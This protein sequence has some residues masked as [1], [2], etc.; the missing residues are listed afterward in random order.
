[1]KYLSPEKNDKMG[2]FHNTLIE[3]VDWVDLSPPEVI[4]ILRMVATRVERLF[5]VS[6][7]GK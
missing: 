7:K 6:V 2:E 1:M 4:A 5:E 3:L